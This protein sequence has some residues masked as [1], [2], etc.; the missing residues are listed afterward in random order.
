[1]DHHVGGLCSVCMHCK[2][3]QRELATQLHIRQ[4]AQNI[5]GALS[6][7]EVKFC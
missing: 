2:R 5:F 4:F 3:Q 6:K 1:M 7:Y